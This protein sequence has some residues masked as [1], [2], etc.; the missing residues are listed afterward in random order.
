VFKEEANFLEEFK[1]EHKV[2]DKRTLMAIF[3][4]IKKGH[5]K[6][7]ESMIKEGK[8]S[9]V[10][11]GKDEKGEWLSIKVYRVLYVDFKNMWTYL[12]TDPR[13][14]RVKKNRWSIVTTWARR[15][16]KNLKTAFEGDVSCPRPIAVEKNV[17]VTEFIGENGIPAP[18]LVEIKLED[19]QEVYDFIIEEMKK[20]AKLNLIHTD[21]SPY[22]IIIYQKP[23]IIDFSQAVPEKH[24]QAKEFLQRDVKNVNEYFK[25]HGAEINENIFNELSNI[26][27]L[28]L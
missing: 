20:L 1:I 26:M 6:T 4:L 7:V 19:Y 10:V 2:F 23:Y 22:N 18:K 15:E 24:P 25:K 13:F 14:E 28:K 11:S 12:A 3:D 27:K 9:I 21:L 17:L 16:F 5:I 8:E